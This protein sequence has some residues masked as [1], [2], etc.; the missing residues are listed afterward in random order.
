M[1]KVIGRIMEGITKSHEWDLE[2]LRLPNASGENCFALDNHLRS[3]NLHWETVI[4][5]SNYA[6]CT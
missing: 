1:V 5:I 6:L 2:I 3:S 4:S